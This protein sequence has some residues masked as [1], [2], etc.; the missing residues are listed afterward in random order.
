MCLREDFSCFMCEF[1]TL[2]EIAFFSFSQLSCIF[3][4]NDGE[5]EM[6]NPNAG[7]KHSADKMNLCNEV[8]RMLSMYSCYH[9]S[10]ITFPEKS[11]SNTS[12][13]KI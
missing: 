2:L 9:H 13:F 6:M 1:E 8:I 11:L 10:S 12:L 5:F 3:G 7:T 4:V